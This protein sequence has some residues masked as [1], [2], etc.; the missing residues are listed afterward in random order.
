MRYLLEALEADRERYPDLHKVYAFASCEPENDGLVH[1]LWAAKAVEPILYTANG[2]DH[3]ALYNS[4]REWR[5][6]ADD[7]TAWRRERLRSIVT[8]APGSVAEGRLEECVALLGHGDANQLLGELSPSAEW[9]PVL[10]ERRVF[11]RDK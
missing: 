10:V 9:L 8:E 5:R 7:P 4:L 6:Y 1:A 2:E 11:D 3:S